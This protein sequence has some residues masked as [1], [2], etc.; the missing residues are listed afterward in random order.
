MANIKRNINYLNRDFGRFRSDLINYAKT[1]FPDTYNDFT[2]AS[3]GMMFMEM[4]S[5]VGDVLSFYLDTQFQETFIQY[6]QQSTNLYDLAYMLGYKPKDTYVATVDLDLYQYIPATGS[7]IN[8]L[9]DWNYALQVAANS[10]VLSS[11][12]GVNFIIENTCDFSFSS[13]QD[14]TEVTV[15]QASSGVPTSYLLRKNRKAYSGEIKTTSFTFGSY[16]PY[17][18][19][20]ITDNN[21]VSVIDVFDSLGNKWYEVDYLAQEMVMDSL[22][23]TN[24]NDPNYFN[25][26]QVPY[27]L[28]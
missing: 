15:L 19:V 5:Y 24:P 28:N 12:G 16:Q 13:S 3:P 8:T 7:G 26:T 18:T 22:K 9:P 21:I 23:N 1:Y 2:A 27:L 14:F 17:Q 25:D 6:A 11:P 20:N 4:A 10:S